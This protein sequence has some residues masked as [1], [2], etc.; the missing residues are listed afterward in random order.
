MRTPFIA[1]NW[2]MNTTASEAV[3]LVT[4]M[5]PLLDAVGGVEKAVCPPFVSLLTVRDAIKGAD[6]KIGAQNMYY[7]EKGA[8]TGEISPTM[9]RDLCEYVIL[10][11]SERRHHFGES[12]EMVGRK[13]QAA[14]KA[15]LKPILCVGENS[16]EYEAGA[17]QVVVSRQLLAGISGGLKPEGLVV[18]YEPVWAIGTG[19]AATGTY[20]NGI[21][22]MIR[23]EVAAVY[24]SAFAESTRIFYGGSVTADNIDEFVAQSEID[25]ALVGGAS[26]K[27]EQF[28]GIVRKTAMA[29]KR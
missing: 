4:E 5:R 29:K 9:L 3:R 8:F 13:V 10:G 17:T 25:G 12:S 6:I 19:K 11:H 20:A 23:E 14:V 21:I 15:G 1:G 28:A 22:G 26:L 27:P 18:A 7:E 24:G 16:A 2:K